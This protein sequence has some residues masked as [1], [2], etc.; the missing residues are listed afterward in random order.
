MHPLFHRSKPGEKTTGLPWFGF[1]ARELLRWGTLDPFVAFSLAQGLAQTRELAAARRA[2][3]ETWLNEQHD[4]VEPDDLIDPQLF[5]E[6]QQ[7]LPHADRATAEADTLT[8][9]LTG[10]TGTRG[11]YRVIPVS[12]GRTINWIDAAGYVLARSRR[13]GTPFRGRLYRDDFELRTDVAEPFVTRVF[14]NR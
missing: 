6:W 12:S 5:L 3:F 11:M 8:A 7:S 2:E 13:D 14:A 9:E 4:D 1:W 10:T